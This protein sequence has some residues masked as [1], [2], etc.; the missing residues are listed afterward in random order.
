MITNLKN[1]VIKDGVVKYNDQGLADYLLKLGRFDP[2]YF[3]ETD[4]TRRYNKFQEQFGTNRFLVN[5]IP[6]V[7]DEW[8]IPDKYFEIDLDE[9]FLD[10]AKTLIE[11][12]RVQ[13]ELKLFR[14]KK[15]TKM[16]YLMM[17]LVDFME[18]NDIVWGVGRGSSVASYILYL[19]GVNDI[20]PIEHDIPIEEFLR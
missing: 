5:Q 15:M 7:S 13:L 14:Q 8:F 3:D 17:Y 4:E 20:D 1:R 11:K 10:K 6:E 18:E 12:E 16:L 2:L 9:H 19:I